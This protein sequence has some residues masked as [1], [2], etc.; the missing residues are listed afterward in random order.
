M[1]VPNR[2][3][4]LFLAVSL[5]ASF[6]LCSS[7]VE[8]VAGKTFYTAVNI[9]YE[10]PGRIESTNYHRGF[11]LPIGTKV[12]I[13]EVTDGFIRFAASNGTMYK[14]L[15]LAKRAKAGTTI[16]EMF[17]QYFSEKDPMGEGG[18][19]RSLTAEEQKAVIDGKIISGMSKS[20]VIMAFGYPP[21][22]RTPSLKE[23]T[24][25]YWESR[26]KT[27]TVTFGNGKVL[28]PEGASQKKRKTESINECIKECKE[29]TKRTPE[30]CFDSCNK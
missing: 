3:A 22:H 16:G 11:V 5:L 17:K 12:K 21:A 10:N 30:Q 23:D 28:G 2:I 25:I 18:A 24:W 13:E 15:F 26:Y 6:A 20:A 27:I 19:F 1:S 9:W 4:I 8:D 14:L 7:A 29:N